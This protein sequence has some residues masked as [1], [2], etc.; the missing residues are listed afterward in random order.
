[1]QVRRL[2]ERARWARLYAGLPGTRPELGEQAMRD[3]R[4]RLRNALQARPADERLAR[5]LA[6]L[7]QAWL[8][9]ARAPAPAWREACEAVLADMREMRAFL[10]SDQAVTAAW[11][12]AQS[13]P[14]HEAE[15]EVALTRD[16]LSSRH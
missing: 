15:A 14:G 12:A 7:D 16:W 8:A 1:M 2:P 13:C 10:R 9:H 6:V 3:T 4:Q 11:L 5:T